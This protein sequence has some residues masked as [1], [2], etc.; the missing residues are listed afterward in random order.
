MENGRQLWQGGASLPPGWREDDVRLRSLLGLCLLL[1]VAAAQ[2]QL[3]VKAR[4]AIADL[5]AASDGP[6]VRVTGTLRDNLGQPVAAVELIVGVPGNEVPVR[7][8]PDGRFEALLEVAVDTT[9]EIQVRFAGNAL[10]SQAKSGAT[11]RIGRKGVQL[12]IAVPAQVEVGEPISATV[13]ATDEAGAPAEDVI[14]QVRLDATPM[15]PLRLGPAG[16]AVMA[17]PPVEPGTHVVHVYWPGDAHRLPAEAEQGF[18]AG[19][20]LGVNLAVVDAAPAP[21]QPV[22]ATGQVIG[23]AEPVSVRLVADGKPLDEVQTGADGHFRMVVEADRLRP[24]LVALR[25][26]ARTNAEGWRDGLSA[27]VTVTVPAPPPPSPWWLWTPGLLA[28]ISL[29]GLLG[30]AW[31]K[32][33]RPQVRA[34]RPVVALPPPFVLEAPA[35]GPTGRLEVELRDALDGRPLQGVVVWLPAGTAN[36]GATSIE[37]PPGRTATTGADGRAALEGG[38]DR[39]W[40]WAEGHAPVCHPL[41]PRGGR[42]RLALLPVRA[43]LQT[44]YDEVLV[45][46]GRPP[47]R[48]G[49]QTPREASAPLLARGAPAEA[50]AALTQLVE[51]ACF[52]E[53]A[54]GHEVLVEAHT[55]AERVRAGL[56]G[57]T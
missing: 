56:K 36:P 4:T 15:P 37:A 54:V 48:F 51:H 40:A 47:L 3:T 21:G 13:A 35:G 12:E 10:L 53:G 9:Q 14:L 17:L 33:P 38:G 46:S 55:L 57:S 1:G 5:R 11:V 2:P 34:P 22:V 42:A 25:A 45:Q 20:S 52:G 39:L 28:A 32:R 29:I 8:G 50:L 24:G 49:R 7:S 41:P 19:R 6:Q 44:L 43:R 31:W 30:R 16:Q 23:P 26:A 18:A 27:V